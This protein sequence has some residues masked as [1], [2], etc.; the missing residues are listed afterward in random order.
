MSQGSALSTGL[1]RP[2]QTS[3]SLIRKQ[4]DAEQNIVESVLGRPTTEYRPYQTNFPAMSEDVGQKFRA[5]SNRA[6]ATCNHHRNPIGQQ[7]G[8]CCVMRDE[9]SSNTFAAELAQDINDQ[10]PRSEIKSGRRF[11]KNQ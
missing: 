1:T 8:F 10:P 9:K 11:I 7:F 3:Q 2:D 4:A 6:Y 5:R